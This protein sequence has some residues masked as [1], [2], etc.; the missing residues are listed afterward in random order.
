MDNPISRLVLGMFI[1]IIFLVQM[2][3]MTAFIYKGPRFTASD[4]QGLCLR[5]QALETE[6]TKKPLPCLYER[7]IQP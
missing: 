3:Q 4:G 5:V 1:F 2:Y 7:D 6:V